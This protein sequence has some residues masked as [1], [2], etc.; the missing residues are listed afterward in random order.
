MTPTRASL[1]STLR[2][3][4]P[5]L[6]PALVSAEAQRAVER[7]TQ[8][9]PAA[10]SSW[11]YLERWLQASAD[12]V[13][14]IV[15]VDTQGR[16]MLVNT[17]DRGRPIGHEWPDGRAWP[18]ISTFA[19]A[20]NDPENA[21][22][23]GVDAIWLE[24]DAPR[25]APGAALPAPRVFLDFARSAYT[26]T[27]VEPRFELAVA[28]LQALLGEAN[29]RPSMAMLERC[30][31]ALPLGAH[32]LYLGTPIDAAEPVPLRVCVS[33]LSDEQIVAYLAALDWPG[34]VDDLRRQVLVPC[35]RAKSAPGKPVAVLHLDMDTQLA[36]RIGLEYAFG[37][38][39]QLRGELREVA[40]LDHLVE[41]GW[42]EAAA[43]AGLVAW[44]GREVAL[45]AHEIWHS[46][47]VRRLSHVKLT[48]ATGEAVRSKAYL[49]FFHELLRSANIARARPPL[50]GTGNAAFSSR[51]GALAA[52]GPAPSH[53]ARPRLAP[54]APSSW[55][56][57][58]LEIRG[59]SR[60]VADG[61][62][63]AFY[64]SLTAGGKPMSMSDKQQQALEAVLQR[65]SVD[66]EFRSRLLTDPRRA[67]QQAFG[68]VIPANFNIKFIEKEASV[69]ALVVLPDYADPTGELNDDDLEAVAGGVEPPAPTWADG[70]H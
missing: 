40:F 65:S 26:Q 4:Q 66:A 57:R 22:H 68:V 11:V 17:G 48:Y 61:T 42:C 47:L 20:W 59:P 64:G 27:A 29:A 15:R 39:S 3:V 1:T 70:G 56:T 7:I 33:G 43:C 18:R 13:D 8:A 41:R 30:F 12:D 58:S 21:I 38:V 46:Q 28:A 9:L 67:I 69:D 24:F 62:Q 34:D 54:Q 49:C 53:G 45:L 36:N 14:L 60:V 6:L 23:A 50:L 19:R 16:A 55:S 51:S 63:F 32:L 2:W 44:P 37:R 10:L 52:R 31:G 5:R 35:A 25:S